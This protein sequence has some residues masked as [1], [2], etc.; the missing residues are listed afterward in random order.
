[1]NKKVAIIGVGYSKFG[2]TT[3]DVSYRE[4]IYEAATRCYEDAG[5]IH[6]TEVD[7]FV[8]SSEDFME[9]V[10]I[11]DEYV[12]DQLGAVLKP[13]Q[14]ITGD[15]LQGLASAMM[16]IQTGQLDLVVTSAFSKASN[17]QQKENVMSYA[18]DPLTVRP[19]DEN[20]N[21]I[22]GLEM[23]RF[24]EETGNTRE[25]CAKVVAKNK[26]NALSNPY[27]SYGANIDAKDVLNSPALFE[28]INRLDSSE[29]LD[30]AIVFLLASEEKALE[31]CENP[32][33]V[34]GI[35]WATDT[36]NLDSRN[37][38]LG[39]A[40]YARLAAQKAYEQAGIK[41][42]RKELSLAEIDDTFSY[43]ELQHIEALKLCSPGESGDLLEQGVFSKNGDLP[44]NVSGGNLGVG[45]MHE[46]NGFQKLLEVV[47]QLRNE[48]GKRQI[49]GANTGLAFA[50][51]N[52]PTAT[53]VVTILSNDRY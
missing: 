30:G 40:V 34:K 47:L 32:V 35:S 51:R 37:E 13:V 25:Q 27:A 46:A 38:G 18:C 17:V 43:K 7:A 20:P 10:S 28:P 6:P 4:M 8:A 31:L 3:P 29:D 22:A 2:S 26:A 41:Y 5:G 11:A 44:V 1:M 45:H 19:L 33:W 36:P 15:G 42:P 14:S 9:G 23:N 39:S 52:I 53:G 12:P 16:Q 21:F 50:W 49:E 24:L 48:A